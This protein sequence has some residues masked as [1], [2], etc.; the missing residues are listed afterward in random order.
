[1]KEIPDRYKKYDDNKMLVMDN[2]YIPK[3]YKKPFAVSCAPILNGLLEKG[4]IIISDTQ[5][6]PYIK[7]KRCFGRALV[8]K[9][10]EE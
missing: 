10:S 6:F 8:Q 9:E 1:L 7:G 5:Y 2:S 3:D 4:Y